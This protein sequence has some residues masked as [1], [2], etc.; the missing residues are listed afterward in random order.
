MKNFV[1]IF[2]FFFVSNAFAEMFYKFV[3]S[4]E[5]LVE[6]GASPANERGPF[7]ITYKDKKKTHFLLVMTGVYYDTCIDLEKRVNTLRKKHHHLLLIGTEGHV[8]DSRNRVWRWRSI[9]SP[10]GS[11]CVSYFQNDCPPK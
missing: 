6:C 3:P 4:N 9:R 2:L 7:G 8:E 5:I 11:E 10:N 1:I